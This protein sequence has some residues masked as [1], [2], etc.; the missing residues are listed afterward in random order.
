MDELRLSSNVGSGQR[1]ATRFSSSLGERVR[2]L[3]ARKGMTRRGARHCVRTSRS[4]TSRISS[5]ASGNASVLVLGQVAQ[6]L[7]CTLAELLGDETAGSPEWLLIR[8][9]LRGRDDDDLRRGRLALAELYGKAGKPAARKRRIALDRPARG[10]QIHARPDA[11]RRSRRPVRRAEPGDRARRGLQRRRDPQPLRADRLPPLRAARARGG[12][13][14]LPGRRDRHAGR[15]RVRRR[16]LQPAALAL[17][18][19]LAARPRPRSTC[20]GS[21]SRAIFARWPA[22]GRRRW[23]TFAGFW[24]RARPSTARPISPSTRAASHWPTRFAQ[25]RAAVRAAVADVTPTTR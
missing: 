13:P 2:S 15:H 7:G 25:L 3:R 11:G 14:A 6:A 22:T 16:H 1:R 9:L 24:R 17:L 20:G 23:R 10:R 5:S 4:G 21:R 12:D 8:E 19:G 18:H